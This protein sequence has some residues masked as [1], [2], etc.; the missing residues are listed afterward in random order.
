MP[1]SW[2]GAGSSTSGWR[3]SRWSATRSWRTTDPD[4]PDHDLTVHVSP[5][6]PTRCHGKAADVLGIDQDR[7]RVITPHVGG[8]FGGQ[9]RPARPSTSVRHGRG[10]HRSAGRWR[11]SRRGRTTCSACPTGGA[12]S[13]TSRWASARDG[14]H[15]RAAVPDASATPAPTPGFGGALAVGP[16]RTMAHGVYRIPQGR[17]RRGGRA[18]EHHADR[19]VPRRGPAGGGGDARAVVDIAADE[20]GIDPVELRRRNLIP[21]DEFPLHDARRAR[22]TTPATTRRPSTKPSRIADYDGP[23]AEQAG[24]ARAGRPRGSSASA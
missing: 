3:W 19:G 5:R 22:P 14:T 17:L 4:D 2:S 15:H 8:A 13:S 23:A 24:A 11:G 12:R 1:T 18:H 20:L 6:C 10:P 16:T 9:G 21:P 7:L